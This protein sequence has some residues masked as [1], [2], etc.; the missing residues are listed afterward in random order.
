MVGY[1]S[2]SL[3][4][5]YFDNVKMVPKFARYEIYEITLH[6]IVRIY[7]LASKEKIQVGNSLWPLSIDFW[8]YS[9]QP[10]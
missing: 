7:N 9:G 8:L 5:C 10:M 4:S 6:K 2:D 3:A 1:P